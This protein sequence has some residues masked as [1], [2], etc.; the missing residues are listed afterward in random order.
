M[1]G[2]L[3]IVLNETRGVGDWRR[4]KGFL[5]DWGTEGASSLPGYD[6]VG[7]GRVGRRAMEFSS[8]V[9]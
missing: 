5:D 4:I 9:V 6:I 1:Y 8:R 3:I 2:S 7:L